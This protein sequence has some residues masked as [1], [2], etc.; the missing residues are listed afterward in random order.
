[1]R[2]DLSDIQPGAWADVRDKVMTGFGRRVAAVRGSDKPEDERSGEIMEA[3]I[4]YQV[5]AWSVADD[6]GDRLPDPAEC[7]ISHLE[8]LDEEILTRILEACNE[9]G[10]KSARDVSGSPKRAKSVSSAS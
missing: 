3:M 6:N 9:V 10:N 2:V 5:R 1:M 7:Q 8:F 4:R